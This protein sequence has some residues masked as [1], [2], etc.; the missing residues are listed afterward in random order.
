MIS[1]FCGFR[2]GFKYGGRVGISSESERHPALFNADRFTQL[3]LE[4]QALARQQEQR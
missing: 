4:T 2:V 3:D 1:T